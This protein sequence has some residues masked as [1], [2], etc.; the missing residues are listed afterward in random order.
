MKIKTTETHKCENEYCTYH[1]LEDNPVTFA[2]NPFSKEVY[3]NDESYW[4]CDM[5]R[6]DAVDGI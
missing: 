5:C 6:C 4:L 1:D 2:P 3:G